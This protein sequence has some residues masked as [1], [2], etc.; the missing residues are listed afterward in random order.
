MDASFSEIRIGQAYSRHE[1]AALWGCA[2]FHALARGV[3]TPQGDN[4]VI[5]FVT[6]EK[7]PSAEPYEDR[8]TDDLLQWEGP[9]D[10]FGEDRVINAK[11]NGEEI[12]LF[13]RD[14]HHGEFI[15]KGKLELIDCRR[16]TEE[17]SKSTFRLI[18]AAGS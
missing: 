10:H 16:L 17:P 12:H 14:R 1:L 2:D 5:L 18:S 11:R 7:Q 9:N 15:Y 13:Y 6:E 8:L 3:V 4:K